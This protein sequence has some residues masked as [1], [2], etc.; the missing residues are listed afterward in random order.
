MM[1]SI[2]Q[3]HWRALLS[4]ITLLHNDGELQAHIKL[5][6]RNVTPHVLAFANAHA[7]N[8]AAESEPFFAALNAADTIYRDGVGMSALFKRLSI[9]P[10]LNLNGTDLIP[11]LISKYDGR[12]IALYGTQ[13]PYLTEAM[14]QVTSS[15]APN[16]NIETANGFLQTHEYI[17]MAMRQRPRL[18]IL[19]MGMPK[20]EQVAAQLRKQL[21]N[22]CLIVCG[23]A[24][25]DFLG[26]KVT[27]APLW[28]RQ[29]SIEWLYRLA[30]EPKRLFKRY[31]LGNPK[32]LA[33]AI[34]LRKFSIA[35][36]AKYSR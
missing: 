6:R 21:S 5:I 29:W 18:I 36:S 8:C 13:D 17:N 14:N 34:L 1:V 12:N 35:A 28:V 2:W 33:R 10:G 27:R 9:S 25:I 24:I 23:G 26:G 20:Q 30:I 31:V 11:R 19:G 4:K 7:M 15:L 3:S 22:G 32:F 16:S